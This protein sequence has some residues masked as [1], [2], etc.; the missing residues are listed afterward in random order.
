MS[1]GDS[2]KSYI[3]FFQNHLAK[4]SNCGEEVFAL[5]FIGGLHV[6]HPLYKHLPKHN[7]IKMSEAL[8]RVQSAHL[9]GGVNV[10]FLQPFNKA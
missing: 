7:V 4:V 6:I 9:T 10:G 3:N 1:P 5:V 2:L 8:S